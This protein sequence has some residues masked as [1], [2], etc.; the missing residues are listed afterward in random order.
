MLLPLS[1]PKSIGRISAFG[2][3]SG[4]VGGIVL[5][6]LLVTTLIPLGTFGVRLS[7]LVCAIWFAVFAIPVLFARP[8]RPEDRDRRAARRARHL[9]SA[10]RRSRRALAAATGTC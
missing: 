2:W 9:P 8:G 5:L 10:D 1:T 4:Y 6:V 7:A 3:A